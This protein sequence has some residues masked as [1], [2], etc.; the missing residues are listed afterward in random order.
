MSF[1]PHW[2][3]QL[4]ALSRTAFARLFEDGSGSGSPQR[5]AAFLYLIAILGVPGLVIP[6]LMQGNSPTD[7][8]GWGWSMIARYH[9]AGALRIVSRADKTF[10]LCYTMAATGVLSVLL[11][12]SLLLDRR[13]RIVLGALPVRSSIVVAARLVAL[14]CLTGAVCGLMHAISSVTFGLFLALGSSPIFALRGIAAHFVASCGASAFVLL[15]VTAVQGTALAMLGPRLHRRVAPVLQL[16]LASIVATSLFVLPVISGSIVDTLAGAGPHVRPEIL[17]TPPVWFLGVYETILGGPGLTLLGLARTAG[18]ALLIVTGAT[19]VSL[20]I[21]YRR[22]M[23]DALGS[24][25][26]RPGR[27]LWA[28]VRDVVVTA[29]LPDPQS[30]A[31]A[32]FFLRAVTRLERHRLVLAI[33]LGAGAA[34][35]LPAWFGAPGAALLRRALFALPIATMLCL[36]VG[37]RVAAAFPAGPGGGWLFNLAPA[38]VAS[39]RAGARRV[40]LIAGVLPVAVGLAVPVGVRLG[41]RA[42]AVHAAFTFLLGAFVSEPLLSTISTVPCAT[43]GRLRDEVAPRHAWTVALTMVLAL[44]AG[45]AAESALA[46][47]A[48]FAMPILGYAAF[49]LWRVWTRTV[50]RA[51]PAAPASSDDLRLEIGSIRSNPPPVDAPLDLRD[52]QRPPAC[53]Q[54]TQPLARVRRLRRHHA[55][56][57]HRG[58]D[59]DVLRVR[60]ARV[61]A[62]ADPARGSHRE[63]RRRATGVAR[64]GESVLGAGLA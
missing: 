20:P 22:T 61:D 12:P 31:I 59:L 45:P 50:R 26:G 15:G 28:R 60:S 7:P 56:D 41:W 54:A 49:L 1:R 64:R 57:R 3:V 8:T 37:L 4:V 34:W 48:G 47:H 10:Y 33:A 39:I 24:T 18:L 40:L 19:L 53:R 11:W 9:G 23:G 38:P 30:R 44:A 63:P 21:G 32:H 17:N 36:L 27:R 62:V 16:A 5:R 6:L 13:D 35:G 42:A 46:A 25:R 2:L 51:A 14:A 55:R 58:H 52:R 43:A 29:G